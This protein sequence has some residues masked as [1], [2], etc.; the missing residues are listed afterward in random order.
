MS[1]HQPNKVA[2]LYIISNLGQLV[3]RGDLIYAKNLEVNVTSNV[4]FYSP[5]R[6]DDPGAQVITGQ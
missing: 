2:K 4:D 3:V 1:T 5:L 6:T